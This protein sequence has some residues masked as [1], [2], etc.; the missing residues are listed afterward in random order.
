[1]AVVSPRRF[2]MSITTHLGSI[3]RTIMR[4][5]RRLW[6][7]LAL[8]CVGY[9]VGWVYHFSVWISQTPAAPATAWAYNVAI[10]VTYA[11]LYVY[12][13]YR[14]TYDQK[15]PARVFWSLLLFS[16]RSEERRVGKASR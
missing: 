1:M 9:V 11:L 7:V 5:K 2:W 14:I 12:L 15:D 13:A 10:L 8:F 16:V 3:S 4:P 6:V